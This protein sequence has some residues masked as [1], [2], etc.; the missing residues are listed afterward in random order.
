MSK[1]FLLIGLGSRT[2]L[3]V[4]V[5]LTAACFLFGSNAQAALVATWS[6]WSAN[7]QAATVTGTGPISS[8]SFNGNAAGSI[9]ATV[10]EPASGGNTSGSIASAGSYLLEAPRFSFVSLNTTTFTISITTSGAMTISMI[11]LSYLRGNS[12]SPTSIAWAV[13]G[14]GASGVI[15]STTLTGTTWQTVDLNITTAVK[16]TG[17][18]TITITGTFSGASTGTAGTIGFDD[19]QVV[20]PEPTSYAL[21]GFGLVFVG[22]GAGRFCLARR[23]SAVAA[24]RFFKTE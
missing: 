21:A 9:L 3:A 14:T 22:V 17:A 10:S 18:N 23:R 11:Q 24:G 19:I 13:S 15:A 5:A 20:V 12:I 7:P 8:G 2:A 4:F 1:K 6:N 16:E